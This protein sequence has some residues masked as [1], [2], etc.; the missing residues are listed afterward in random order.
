MSSEVLTACPVKFGNGQCKNRS[1]Y[2]ARCSLIAGLL[3]SRFVCFV[4]EADAHSVPDAE[5]I[6]LVISLISDI[7][8]VS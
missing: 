6:T 3:F 8:K 4:P 2:N 1:A 5:I 7:T